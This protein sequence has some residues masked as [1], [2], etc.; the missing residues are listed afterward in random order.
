MCGSHVSS[1]SKK[2]DAACRECGTAR[3]LRKRVFMQRTESAIRGVRVPCTACI[4]APLRAAR[5][6][7]H[8]QGD[9]HFCLRGLVA[10]AAAGAADEAGDAAARRSGER[11]SLAGVRR[12]LAWHSEV[13]PPDGLCR[14]S[15][16]GL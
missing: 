9:A 5:Q 16:V 7:A 13:G 6:H 15:E 8:G 14:L 11:P 4:V 3:Q 12:R 1:S 10:A 2:R